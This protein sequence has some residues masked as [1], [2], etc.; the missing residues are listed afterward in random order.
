VYLIFVLPD[1]QSASLAILNSAQIY[2]CKSKKYNMPLS[3]AEKQRRHRQK[4]KERDPEAAKE[5]E[6]N[7]WRRRKAEGKIKVFRDLTAREQRAK[8]K[9][10]KLANANR[11]EQRRRSKET[12]DETSEIM[13]ESTI[14]ES[15]HSLPTSSQFLSPQA[16]RGR[17]RLRKD[18][19]AAYLEIKKLSSKISKLEKKVGKMKKRVQRERKLVLGK[20]QRVE[21]VNVDSENE[22]PRKKS[23]RMS[24]DP[25]V[26][27]VLKFHY[28]LTSELKTRYGDV[29]KRETGKVIS[30]LF[31]TASILKK[32]RVIKSAR[33]LFGLTRTTGKRLPSSS[34][35]SVITG[36][37][38]SSKT[39]KR[40]LPRDMIQKIK[41]FYTRDDISRSTAGKRETLTRNKVKK[42]KRFLLKPISWTYKMYIKE[43]VGKD[44]RNISLATFRRHRPFWVVRPSIK[45][46][47]TCNCQLHENATFMHE[48]LKQLS[49]VEDDISQMFRKMICKDKD[50]D[51]KDCMYR[52]CVK[53]CKKNAVNMTEDMNNNKTV[54]NVIWWWQWQ[55]VNEM[56]GE[57]VIKKTKKIRVQGTVSDLAKAYNKI[58]PNLSK[59]TF[60]IKHQFQITKMK[61]ESL[62]DNELLL[63]IDFAENWC[64]KSLTE[65]QACHFGG[66]H[67]QVSLHTG[68]AYGGSFGKSSF[69]SVSDNTDHGPVAIW[70]HLM[71]VLVDFKREF[72]QLVKLHFMSDGPVTQYRGRGNV[73]LLANV[74]YDLGFE[75][76]YWNYSEASHGKG[77][78]DGV[79]AGIKRLCDRLVLSGRELT[80]AASICREMKGLTKS[81][82]YEVSDF[83]SI[84]LPDSPIPCIQ[85]IMRVHQIYSN[86]KGTVFTRDVSCYCSEQ[87]CWCFNPKKRNVL[88]YDHL[89]SV[90]LQLAQTL[91]TAFVDQN[92]HSM[93]NAQES[94]IAPLQD[95]P[96]MESM[97][98][99]QE[100]LI[101]PIQDPRPI[102]CMDNAQESLI[103]PLQDPPPME[104]MDN[105]Q[106]SL[107]A[108]IQNPRPIE[109]MDNAQESLIAPLQDPPPMESMDN[110]QESL[111]SIVANE[112]LMQ[113]QAKVGPKY[114]ESLYL[115]T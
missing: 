91:V 37:S 54:S 50:T 31:G 24:S 98:N 69:C 32:Y 29:G 6:R 34:H 99:A 49:L 111:S 42:Q 19:T 114:C 84:R 58:M 38:I 56:L 28:A 44:A 7:R 33:R 2:R 101:A 40:A 82:V 26:R 4:M 11:A 87:L 36:K 47:E 92:R 81:R 79:G 110:A 80:D 15:E 55:P 57:K 41:S 112:S 18:R 66:S 35:N 100:S 67:N 70:H 1:Y 25:K 107:I 83:G 96:P 71:P 103:A 73:H 43:N 113:Q 77:A 60:N 97:D 5:K 30:K 45:D 63:H 89:Q 78:P 74:P 16:V 115:H 102:E 90:V 72:P 17:K 13:L 46:R 86:T 61:K 93:D 9:Q 75:E 65:V 52:D 48:R 20:R 88:R 94:L 27:K 8:R 109:S 3:A 51:T 12:Q 76:V 85:G 39:T 64:C 106:E 22:T 104:S 53:C 10:W 62:Q 59:H 23:K 14:E 108:P 95:P 68:V 105:A 21:S